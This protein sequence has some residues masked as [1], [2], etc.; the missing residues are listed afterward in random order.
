MKNWKITLITMLLISGA[1]ASAQTLSESQAAKMDSMA[2]ALF[3]KGNFSKSIELWA[4][5]KMVFLHFSSFSFES[6]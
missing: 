5:A 6:L 4:L 1:T 2:V 3:V